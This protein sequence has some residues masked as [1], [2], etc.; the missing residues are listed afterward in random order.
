MK[1]EQRVLDLLK[2][3]RNDTFT[4]GD[5]PV[6]ERLVCERLSGRNDYIKAALRKLAK[7]GK[8]EFITTGRVKFYR[9]KTR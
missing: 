5:I 4:T 8:I 7:E 6:S 1:T 3:F 2:Q 9:S